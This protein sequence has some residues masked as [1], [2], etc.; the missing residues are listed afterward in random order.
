MQS[1]LNKNTK[2]RIN[3]PVG[4][5]KPKDTGPIITQGSVEVG[6]LS[7][8]SIDNGINVTFANSD[9]EVVYNGLKLGPLNYQ[10]DIM[11][12]AETIASAQYSNRLMEDLF[13]QK[14]L[15]FNLS[16]SQFLIMGSRKARKKISDELKNNPIK[17]CGENM[18]EAKALKYLGEFLSYDLEDSVHQTVIRRIGIAKRTIF[19]IRAVIEDSRAETLGPIGLA[20]DIWELALIPMITHHTETWTNLSRKTVKVL[21]NLFHGFCKINERTVVYFIKQ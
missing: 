21:D 14:S 20:F 8:V 3:T 4:V 19:E 1:K 15:S 11:R 13:N 7:S 5:S 9:C 2:I 10:D 6:V 12:M 17:L 18:K 16:K